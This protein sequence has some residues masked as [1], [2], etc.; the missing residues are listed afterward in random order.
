MSN[1]VSVHFQRSLCFINCAYLQNTCCVWRCCCTWGMDSP[2]PAFARS[3]TGR[4]SRSRAVGCCWRRCPRPAVPQVSEAD[5]RPLPGLFIMNSFL[6][7]GLYCV[8]LLHG[9][10]FPCPLLVVF[11]FILVN[12]NSPKR[13]CIFFLLKLPQTVRVS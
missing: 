11:C 9:T 8:I 2:L 7:L 1:Q 13:R 6:S 4:A 12:P 5:H 3:W 10:I